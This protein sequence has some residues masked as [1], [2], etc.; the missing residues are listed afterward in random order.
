MGL[1]VCRKMWHLEG[2]FVPDLSRGE[3]AQ[4]EVSEERKADLLGMRSRTLGSKTHP[5]R[6]K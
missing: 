5:L 3:K 1:Q 6:F 2:E 4:L